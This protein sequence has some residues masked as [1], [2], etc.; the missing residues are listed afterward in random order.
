MS[1]CYST[2]TALQPTYN[3]GGY[4]FNKYDSKSLIQEDSILIVGR[5]SALDKTETLVAPTVKYGCIV[6]QPGSGEYR[7]KA[8]AA[9]VKFQLSATAVGYLTVET[10]PL[11]T[12][13]GDSVIVDFYLAPDERPLLNCEGNF[14]KM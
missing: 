14:G 13:K 2:K 12:Q 6:Q 8:K 4:V 5:I 9:D 3:K 11:L 7:I 10:Q 1:S